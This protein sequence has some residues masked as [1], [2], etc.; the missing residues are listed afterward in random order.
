MID[1]QAVLERALRKYEIVILYQ[2][3]QL[4]EGPD[5]LEEEIKCTVMKSASRY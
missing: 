1:Y 3:V 4:L 2:A 5:D